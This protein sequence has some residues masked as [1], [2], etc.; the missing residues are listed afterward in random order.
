MNLHISLH[1][2]TVDDLGKNRRNEFYVNDSRAVCVHINHEDH[3]EVAL[4][5]STVADLDDVVL[6]LQDVVRN[7]RKAPCDGQP[8]FIWNDRA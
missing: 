4:W 2:I 3:G 1:D 8:H 5:F 6:W 7:A